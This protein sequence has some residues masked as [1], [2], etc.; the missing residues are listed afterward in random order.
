MEVK[1]IVKLCVK[2][3]KFIEGLRNPDFLF[4]L[5]GEGATRYGK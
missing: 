2:K 1:L 4:F 3:L 5:K